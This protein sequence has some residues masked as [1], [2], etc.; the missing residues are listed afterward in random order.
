MTPFMQAVKSGQGTGWPSQPEGTAPARMVGSDREPGHPAELAAGLI[1]PA[2]WYPLFEQALR[3]SL[4]RT[5]E[6][7]QERLGRLWA[8]FA[9]VA[10]DNPYAWMRVGPGRGCHR[11][12]VAGQSPGLL[13]VHEAHEREHPGRPG[14]GAR[15]LLRAGGTRRRDP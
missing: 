9:G 10:A 1:A 7:H 2:F 13:A 3:R 4:G 6:D 11:P 5:Q 8:R 14:R 12:P 15:A